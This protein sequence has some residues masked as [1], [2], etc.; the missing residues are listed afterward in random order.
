MWCVVAGSR[1]FDH[2]HEGQFAGGP[3]FVLG[4]TFKDGFNICGT[5]DSD[6]NSTTSF[7]ESFG[8]QHPGGCYFSFCDG[9]ARFVFDSV[10]PSIMNALATRDTVAKEG[11]VDPIIHE[12]PF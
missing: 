6:R 2:Q 10:D 5:E 4:T 8:S 1:L 7:A 11:K 12:S 9:G 3:G